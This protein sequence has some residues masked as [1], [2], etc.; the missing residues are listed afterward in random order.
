MGQRQTPIITMGILHCELFL[1]YYGPRGLFQGVQLLSGC[2]PI[3]LYDLDIYKVI[4]T[5]E[6][7]QI[8]HI[9][10]YLN[11]NLGPPKTYLHTQNE[12]ST[13]MAFMLEHTRKHDLSI[14]RCLTLH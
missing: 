1:I 6:F 5:M 4:Q 14:Y 11:L 7:T 3:C 10:S 12:G 2:M 9:H 13:F 8:T